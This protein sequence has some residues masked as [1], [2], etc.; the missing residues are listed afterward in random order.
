MTADD[1]S[2]AGERSSVNRAAEPGSHE[3]LRVV[4]RDGDALRDRAAR[5]FAEAQY[6]AAKAELDAIKSSAGWA[7]LQR[8]Y[9]LRFTLLPRGS[10]REAVAQWAARSFRRRPPRKESI[11]VAAP[12][13][14]RS[15]EPDAVAWPRVSV[16]IVTYNNVELNEL[17][18]QTVLTDTDY[19]DYEVI[20]VDNGST[21]GTQEM[22]ERMAESEPR[23]R[24]LLQSGN[25]GFAAASN[26]GAS[27]ASGAVLCFLNND[28]V[29]HGRWLRSLVAHLRRDTR[30]G[31]VG[32]ATNAIDNQARV[33][34][35]YADLQRMHAWA[36]AYCNEHAG[37]LEPIPMLAFFCVAIP[38]AV[39]ER[40]GPLD[41]Q[42]TIGMFEDDDYCRR[43]RAEGFDVKL[44]RDS[45]VHHWQAASFRMLGNDE[46][47]R[48]RG[49][50]EER[51]RAKWGRR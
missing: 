28:T 25:T 18:L 9:P 46:Y 37:N 40:V 13:D 24:L 44:A 29:P 2:P 35:D 33:D 16:V 38:R 14:H 4:A 42:F 19:P 6:R 17:C 36:D 23:V 15:A 10:R 31:L 50:N 1:A 5:I 51:F 20:V 22:L 26:A 21:D 48:I 34:V 49:Q 32:P 11:N 8:L 43:V 3:A 47:L 27:L 12:A 41:E 7:L 45:F 39:W 30:L